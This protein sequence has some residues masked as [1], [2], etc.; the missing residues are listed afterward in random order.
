MYSTKRR[1]LSFTLVA[2]MASSTGT[3]YADATSPTNQVKGVMAVEDT[4]GRVEVLANQLL[5]RED[6]VRRF[7]GT[8]YMHPQ[9]AGHYTGTD[10]SAVPKEIIRD[11]PWYCTWEAA[12]ETKLFLGSYDE[13]LAKNAMSN[14][15]YYDKLYAFP[16]SHHLTKDGFYKGDYKTYTMQFLGGNPAIFIRWCL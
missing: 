3:V 9:V 6:L 1:L 15:N 8:V 16:M 12:Y 2:L 7:L 11:T 5:A 14:L 13:K 10:R 4:K